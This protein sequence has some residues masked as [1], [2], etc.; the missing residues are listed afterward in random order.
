MG[1]DPTFPDTFP[2]LGCPESG[3]RPHLGVPFQKVGVRPH[4]GVPFF[5]SLFARISL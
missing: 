3:V 2:G 4:L 5:V 1:T